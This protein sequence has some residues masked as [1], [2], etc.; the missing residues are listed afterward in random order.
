M[1]VS[2]SD[3]GGLDHSPEQ[4]SCTH[5]VFNAPFFF[6]LNTEA[7]PMTLRRL[8]GIYFFQYKSLRLMAW[9]LSKPIECPNGDITFTFCSKNDLAESRTLTIT[10]FWTSPSTFL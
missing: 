8:L 2:F 9:A 7:Q 3:C 5:R 6:F 10:P 4:L 1:T